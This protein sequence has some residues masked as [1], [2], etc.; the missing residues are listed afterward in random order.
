MNRESAE[1]RAKTEAKARAASEK[2]LIKEREAS[3]KR[4]LKSQ[5]KI[6]SM[7]IKAQ[8]KKEAEQ[9]KAQAKSEKERR[10][11]SGED[12]KTKSNLE[13][14]KKAQSFKTMSDQEVRDAIA[15]MKLEK[16]YR[17]MAKKP[18]SFLK[19]SLKKV[20]ATLVGGTMLA[21]GKAVLTKQLTT[22]GNEKVEK[23]IADRQRAKQDKENEI[24]NILYLPGRDKTGKAV[25]YTGDPYAK[26]KK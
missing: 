1:R 16:E 5:E 24:L 2:R 9:R 19:K 14:D 8:Q 11:Q 15:R 25:G 6:A 20:A 13:K 23:V 4:T 22:I 10:K 17:D 21:V 18:D 12:K 26:K 7:Q 3:Q